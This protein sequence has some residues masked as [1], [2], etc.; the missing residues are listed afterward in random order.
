MRWPISLRTCTLFRLPSNF[1]L[2]LILRLTAAVTGVVLLLIVYFLVQ[3]ALPVL[4]Q[5]G[6]RRFITDAAWNPASG[7]FNLKPIFWGTVLATLGSITLAAP[8]GILSAI[9]CLHYAPTAVAKVYRAMIELMAGIPSVVYG[10]WGLVV[11]VPF[12]V[13]KH[14]PGASLAVAIVIL[15]LMILP[16]ITLVAMASLSNLPLH[17]QQ[18]SAALGLSR[19]ATVWWVLIPAAKSGI[20]TSVVLATGR[21]LGETMAV[22]MVS[23]NVVQIPKTLFDPMRTLA[24]NIALEMAYAMN[25]HRSALFVSALVLMILVTAL[26]LTAEGLSKEKL[27][28]TY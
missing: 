21:A 9:F 20:A 8:L 16:T 12:L 10:F 11:L 7:L 23:G 28:G 13:E 24:A 5:A 22:L 27:D 2:P 3:G 4:L 15:T 1:L 25:L 6:W 17:L 18:G 26:V 14:P 19:A